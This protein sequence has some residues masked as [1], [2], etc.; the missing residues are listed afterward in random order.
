MKMVVKAEIQLD[1]GTV[2][3]RTLSSF[4]RE[5]GDLSLSN[6]GITIS[7]GKTL[8][9]QAQQCLA[10]SQCYSVVNAG[11]EPRLFAGDA[12]VLILR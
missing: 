5:V 1:D 2:V 11:Q 3:E 7:D 12:A 8:L 6:L 10:H 9:R 4:E